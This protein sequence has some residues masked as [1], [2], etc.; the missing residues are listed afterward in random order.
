M[1]LKRSSALLLVLEVPA[2]SILSFR[3]KETMLAW[4]L[5]ASAS[6]DVRIAIHGVE[7]SPSIPFRLFI[8]RVMVLSSPSCR[9]D[10][11]DP[12]RAG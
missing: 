7:L 11:G 4:S 6:S 10:A 2:H 9:S 3:S 5:V 12:G 8:Q 1:I